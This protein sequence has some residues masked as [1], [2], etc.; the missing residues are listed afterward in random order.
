[1]TPLWLELTALYVYGPLIVLFHELGHAAFARRGGFRVT[2][3]AVGMGRPLI[4]LG[5]VR[6]A[7]VWVGRW[8]FGGGFCVAIPITPTTRQ[9][10]WFYGGGLLV[11]VGLALALWAGPDVWW[12][13]RAAQF[14]VLVFLTNAIPWR[15]GPSASDGWMLVDLIRGARSQ[16]EI[17]PQ[18]AALKKVALRESVVQS[19]LGEA[20]AGLCLAWGDVVA[21]DLDTAATFLRTPPD[22]LRLEP[23]VDALATY[24]TAEWH[25]RAGRPQDALAATTTFSSTSASEA[26]HGFVALAHAGALLD[27]GESTKARRVLEDLLGGPDFLVRQALV[28]LLR[29]S[30]NGPTEDIEHAAWRVL[31]H[32]DAAWLDPVGTATTLQEAADRLSRTNRAT[33]ATGIEQAVQTLVA[34]TLSTAHSDHQSTLQGEFA[35][36]NSSRSSQQHA[37]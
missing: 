18:R 20:W 16:S 19:P 4:R 14:N 32:M 15:W 8:V 9:R 27:V 5:T 37:P 21:G 10:G 24:V 6:G 1:M 28:L 34:R 26:A 25:R 23:Y 30:L 7:V 2:S 3:F 29:A 33:A 36:L 31:R 22:E 17:L 13:D 11:Q 35:N 12:L